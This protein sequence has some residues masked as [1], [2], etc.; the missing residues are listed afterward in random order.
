MIQQ[1]ENKAELAA[2]SDGHMVASHATG[3]GYLTGPGIHELPVEYA[4]A[5]GLAIHEGCIELGTVEDV[6]AE[7][8]RI[9]AE[10]LGQQPIRATGSAGAADMASEDI[11]RG[12]GLP[13]DSSF[14]WTDGVL[15]YT[16]ADSVPDQN[17]V[18]DAV[19]HIEEMTGIRFV[20]RTSGNAQRYPNYVEIISNGN[21][22]WSSSAIGMR[23]GRQVLRF[24]DR[25]S[26]Q[27]LVHEFLHALGVYHEQSRSDRDDFV[28]IQ[29]SNI[30]DDAIG[31]FQKKPD[32]IDY[33]DYDYGSI[34][35]YPRTSFA[36]D[37]SQPTIVPL[38]SGVTIGQRNGMSYGDRQ[39]IAKM[40][41]RFFQ[42]G[43]AG[44]WR[45][46]TGRYGLW[47]NA[48][49]DSFR[50]KWEEWSNQGLRLH[51]IHVQRRD[52]KTLYSGVFLPG[53]GAYGLWANV[54]WDNFRNKW[55]E[56]SNQGLR[57]VDLH[58]HR[59]GNQNRYSGVFL[60]GTG[61][62]GLWAN[63][64]W[65]SFVSKWQEWSS[66]G[67]RLVDLNLHKDGDSIR[68]SG[69]FLPGKDGY[70]LWANVTFEGFRAKWQELA[71]QGLRLIDFEIAQ[72]EDG[73]ENA[74]MDGSEI[75]DGSVPQEFGGVFGGEAVQPPA[76]ANGNGGVR[77]EGSA[78]PAIANDDA[79]GGVFFPTSPSSNSTQ[80]SKLEGLGGVFLDGAPT[81]STPAKT[82][83]YGGVVLPN[84]LDR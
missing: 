1:L 39:T 60:P 12:I 53:T 6:K 80:P 34:M 55:E 48:E 42:R 18:A 58:V 32:A 70:Y 59:V 73:A 15:I 11:Q 46:G 7:A 71:D 5:N 33:F 4:I 54:K 28:A 14:L 41:E 66:Q 40:Y 8:D 13:T 26:W 9:L 29:W 56:W 17:R 78:S 79:Q 21:E 30:Q 38:Q 81:D 3:R 69:T 35:H 84:L 72:P 68:Y 65:S 67:L 31:N 19:R 83:G 64:T 82:E 47:V 50:N 2:S 61:G 36:K 22:G 16:I 45:A 63:T 23:G 44:V 27:I 77:T 75:A 52:G 37:S 62:Y 49:W 43:Y 74:A 24:S 25:H 20:R 57:L 51:D 10:H 76:Y